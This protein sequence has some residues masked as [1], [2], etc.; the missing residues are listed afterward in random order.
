[1]FTRTLDTLDTI[2]RSSDT[3]NTHS[4]SFS[5]VPAC[6]DENMSKRA[7]NTD[8]EQVSAKFRP[9]RGFCVL[10][11]NDGPEAMKEDGRKEDYTGNSAWRNP[12]PSTEL[13]STENVD[14]SSSVHVVD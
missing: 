11:R 1:M 2:I 8:N 9:V 7:G 13:P 14:Q 10:E 3:S 6:F 4:S 5:L 12:M